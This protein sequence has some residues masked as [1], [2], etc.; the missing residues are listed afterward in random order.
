M[1]TGKYASREERNSAKGSQ[2]TAATA[3]AKAAAVVATAAA[4]AAAAAAVVVVTAMFVLALVCLLNVSFVLKTHKPVNPKLQA[5]S[6]PNPKGFSL[7]V[8]FFPR[9]FPPIVSAD[10]RNEQQK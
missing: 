4:A 7:S 2:A 6:G 9:G 1:R 5:Q 3:A 10:N 8:Y